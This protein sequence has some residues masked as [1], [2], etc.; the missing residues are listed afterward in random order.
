MF[1][2]AGPTRTGPPGVPGPH[3]SPHARALSIA[4]QREYA[5]EFVAPFG[6]G[7]ASLT[8]LKKALDRRILT[9][10]QA[11]CSWQIEVLVNGIRPARPSLFPRGEPSSDGCAGR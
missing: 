7:G 6:I 8:F 11:R 10:R 2:E 3:L 1:Q 4:R 5:G 9:G